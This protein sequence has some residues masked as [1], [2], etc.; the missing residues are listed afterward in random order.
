MTIDTPPSHVVFGK[1]HLPL[2]AQC[3]NLLRQRIVD[4][5]WPVGSKL[6]TV[7]YLMAELSV[8]RITIR[9]AIK[10]L[11]EEGLVQALR[12]LGT[13]VLRQPDKKRSLNL[14]YSFNELVNVYRGDTPFL[15]NTKETNEAPKIDESEGKLLP[16]YTHIRRVHKRGNDKYCVIS[17][18]IAEALFLEAPDRFRT[19]LALPVLSSLESFKFAR[20]WQTLRISKASIETSNLIGI[21]VG[22]PTAEV[23]RIFQAD[24]G[25]ILYLADITYRGDYIQ[26]KMDLS[27]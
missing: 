22:D 23:R 2:Y 16:A 7:D 25:S 27:Q 3:A 13:S 15:A 6:P 8:S 14:S 1:S 10:M 26:L 4:D 24:D 11:S 20:S 17:L 12:G 21:L 18:Y 19:E 9:Q 5:I